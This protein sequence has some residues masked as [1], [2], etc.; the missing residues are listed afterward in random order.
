MHSPNAKT[1]W[2]YYQELLT[3]SL[4]NSIPLKTENDII[5]AVENFEHEVQQTAWNATPV[6]K[7]TNISFEY[8][9]AIKDKLAEKRK[10]RK[11]RQINR[12]PVL[13]AKL[14]GA[15][16]ALQNL[17]KKE[18]NQEIQSYLSEL[19]LSA[20][21]NCSPWKA[22]RSLE[23]PQKEFPPIRKQD[24]RCA[25]RDEEKAEV[26]AVQLFK[27]FEPHPREIIKDE[28]KKLLKDTNS[29]AQTA[30]PAIPFTVNEI[31]AAIRVLNPKKAPGYDL[32]TDQVLQKLPEKSIRFITHFV[33]QYSD[34]AFFYLQWRVAQIIMIQKPSK[35]AELAASYRP[36]SL[37]PVLSKLFEKLLLPRLLEIIER[38][39][40]IPNHPF[41]FRPRHATTEQIHRIVEK[42]NRDMETGRHGTA[43]FLD[44]TQAFD[45][46]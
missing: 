9:S 21:T 30:A 34:K 46:V 35:S 40:I 45:K 23:R 3:T 26:F 12:C 4:N 19:S 22:A 16:K 27:V 5:C 37:L 2:S 13:K 43:A 42:I 32:I 20:E 28:E 31:R 7:S 15:I 36:I 29:S 24:E 39:K 18:R 10:L 33:T 1:D 8:S 14:N 44:V 11:L 41:E 6:C 38:Q 17:L 25:R